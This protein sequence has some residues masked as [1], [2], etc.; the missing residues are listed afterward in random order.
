MFACAA[1]LFAQT[2]GDEPAT[3]FAISSDEVIVPVTVT[4]QEGSFVSDLDEGDF[5]IFD[6]GTEQEITFFSRE[7]NQPIV[8]G[9]LID[10]SNAMRLH[11][12]RFRESAIELVL[13]LMPADDERFSGYVI[14][15]HTQA[16]L[17]VN[18]TSDVNELLDAIREMKPGG[19]STLFDA[20]Y[21]AATS[22]QLV[23]G[24]PIEPRRVLVVVGDGH[25]NASSRTLDQ[26]LE[27][28]QRNLITIYCLSTV[29]F[30]QER[31]EESNLARLANET[32][33][34]VEYPLDDL[35]DDVTGYISNPQDAGNYALTVGTGSYGAHV[36]QG[37]FESVAALVGE[38]TTQYILRYRPTTT[39]APRIFR[40]VR[41]EVALP[42]VQVRHRRGYYPYDP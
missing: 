20:I 37:I 32:G 3:S 23:V 4:D 38:I 42:N 18:T 12:D 17:L 24:E 36:M 33:G 5:R 26:V 14:S 34:R 31:D 29:P 22:R 28:A 6:Q 2:D 15:Y 13:A 40:N 16:E 30:E 35:Y 41:V 11:W 8:I 10:Q 9:F 19:G 1:C 39:D 25:D 21:M 7:R 27:L